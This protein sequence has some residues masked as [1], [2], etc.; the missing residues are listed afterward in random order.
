M[1]PGAR[2]PATSGTVV[3]RLRKPIPRRP[4]PARP[5]C[6]LEPAASDPGGAR[7]AQL[8]QQAG[9]V[10]DALLGFGLE[11]AV[12]GELAALLATVTDAVRA[13]AGTARPLPVF[14]VDVPTGIDSDTGAVRG[15][16][17]PAQVT[18]TLGLAKRGLYL[19]PGA[20]YAGTIVLGDIGVGDLTDKLQVTETTAEQVRALLPARPA[21]ANKGTFGSVLIVAGSLNYIGAGVLATLGAMRVGVGLATLATP[22]DLLPIVAAKLTECTFLPLPADMGVLTERAVAPLFEAL[23][24]R[25]YQ[26]LLVGNGF[27]RE[28]ETLAFVREI[29]QDHS[30]ASIAARAGAERHV[31]FAAPH[32]TGAGGSRPAE[33]TVG[34]G[35]VR[36]AVESTAE[37]PAPG[38]EEELATLPPLVIDADGLNLLSE[39]EDWATHL[40]ENSILTPHPGEMA[41]LHGGD[42]A[43]IQADRIGTARA[44]AAEWKQIVVLKGAHTVIAAPDGRV[45]V[46]PT[47]SA[48][49][50]TA[51]TGDVLAGV[52]AGLLAQGLAPFDAA[53]VGVY[54][55][56]QAGEWVA[57]E[58][59]TAGV[60]AG[61]IAEALPYVLRETAEPPG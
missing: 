30:A 44:A 60:I 17:L 34:F 43:A 51:G 6:S 21:D 32:R 20:A 5:A 7:L 19:F 13:R 2:S 45:Q 31:G 9:A 11:R 29:F 26:A 33:R 23:A 56:G 1:T 36:R 61:D 37:T 58:L 38:K 59:G 35:L 42:I 14:A 28:K 53:V 54:L 39:I 40:P 12:Q 46:N 3:K 8:L 47:A 10:V 22:I 55:H 15:V 57:H 48:A 41:R 24:K 18:I 50:A 4:P 52:I 27:G 16:A 49:L 25:P